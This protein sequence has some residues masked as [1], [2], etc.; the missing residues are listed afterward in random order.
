M[1]KVLL[2]LAAIA[3]TACTDPTGLLRVDVPEA[4]VRIV[5]VSTSAQL[6]SALNAALPGDS[7]V[8]AAGTYTGSFVATRPGMSN[9]RIYLI[10]PRSA[11][12]Q[13]TSVTA[14]TVLKLDGAKYWT[15]KGFTVSTGLKGVTVWAA[16]RVFIDSLEVKN[17]GQ[18]AIAMGRFSPA[19][20]IRKNLVHDTGK[21]AHQFGEGIYIG[22]SESNWCNF[23]GCAPDTTDSVQVVRNTIYNAKADLIQVAAGT[24]AVSVRHNDLNG[25]GLVSDPSNPGWVLAMGNKML[26]DSNTAVDALTYGMKVRRNVPEWGNNNVFKANTMTVGTSDPAILLETAPANG[27]VVYCDNVRTDAGNGPLSNIACTP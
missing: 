14:A 17:T 9:A 18:E 22:T 2:S 19:G 15:L 25:A 4:A 6:T 16:R 13:N 20:I 1:R 23:T 24:S 12:L 21:S 27:M 7:I 8:L 10:G 11:V 5:R 26:V 3:S